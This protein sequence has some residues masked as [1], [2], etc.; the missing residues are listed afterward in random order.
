MVSL[1]RMDSCRS[2]AWFCD[3]I[4]FRRSTAPPAQPVPDPI[5]LL[6]RVITICLCKMGSNLHRGTDPAAL[7]LGG[8]WSCFTRRI[9][10][11]KHSFTASLPKIGRI[12]FGL[13]SPLVGRDLWPGGCAPALRLT[14]SGYLADLYPLELDCELAR[15]DPGWYACRTRQS[16]R[17]DC[18]SSWLS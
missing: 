15:K 12:L 5:H 9:H 11:Q 10:H 18:L 2:F 14:R 7:G 17:D 4:H 6:L 16:V 3:L 8:G 1:P 13:R